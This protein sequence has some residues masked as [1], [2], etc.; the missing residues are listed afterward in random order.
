MPDPTEDPKPEGG[1][2]NYYKRQNEKLQQQIDD[3]KAAQLT[4]S[5]RYRAQAETQTKR[6]DAAEQKLRDATLHAHFEAAATKAGALNPTAAR[7]LADLSGFT[8]D[9]SGKVVGSVDKTMKELQAEHPYLFAA[10]ALGAGAGGATRPAGVGMGTGG[11]GLSTGAGGM[12]AYMNEAIRS[13][14]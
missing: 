8:L 6:A 5:E 10:K 12:N 3:I 4:E 1:T 7:K 14:F 9:E 2:E 13:Q 11:A